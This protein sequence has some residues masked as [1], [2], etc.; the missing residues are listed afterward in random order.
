MMNY[1]DCQNVDLSVIFISKRRLEQY[2]SRGRDLANVISSDGYNISFSDV[3]SDSS[4]D[5]LKTLNIF[6]NKY[7]LGLDVKFDK[8]RRL[9]DIESMLDKGPVSCDDLVDLNILY[10]ISTITIDSRTYLLVSVEDGF[11]KEVFS[12]RENLVSFYRCCV[13]C[14]I[15]SKCLN[16]EMFHKY[17]NLQR[18]ESYYTMLKT[19]LPV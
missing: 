8:S 7:L 5:E 14:L 19:M 17:Y 1:T 2:L 9:E 15:K 12:S 13:L 10:G 18:N 3:F 6:Y 4:K 16:K 11:L